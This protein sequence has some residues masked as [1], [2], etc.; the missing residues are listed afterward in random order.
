MCIKSGKKSN[1]TY[2]VF[3][4]SCHHQS[5]LL[6]QLA[7]CSHTA[8][9]KFT[10]ISVADLSSRFLVVF[11]SLISVSGRQKQPATIDF[12]LLNHSID[13]ISCG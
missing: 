10:M 8:H 7:F 6:C 13:F 4:K 9:M 1:Q 2:R 11:V 12:K 5:L 3:D